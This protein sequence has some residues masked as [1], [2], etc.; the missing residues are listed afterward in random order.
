LAN[1]EDYLQQF[2]NWIS[3]GREQEEGA[4][5]EG[6]TAGSYLR[7][8]AQAKAALLEGISKAESKATNGPS[9]LK[10]KELLSYF[11]LVSK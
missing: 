5:I 1:D 8:A 4:G 2:R 6:D 3:K 10:F 11:R 7:R 9:S